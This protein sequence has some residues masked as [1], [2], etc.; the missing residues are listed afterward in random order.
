[1]IY[2][3][4]SAHDFEMEV[5]TA[6]DD[7]W[8]DHGTVAVDYD[9]QHRPD[10]EHPVRLT[11]FCQTEDGSQETEARFTREQATD[12]ADALIRD[13]GSEM[14]AKH[15]LNDYREMVEHIEAMREKGLEEGKLCFDNPEAEAYW[16]GAY[17]AVFGLLR[18]ELRPMLEAWE[19]GTP[20]FRSTEK[21]MGKES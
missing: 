2:Q 16:E 19:S 5:E 4:P 6:P 12:L 18:D 10:T 3:L 9:D 21:M 14:E 8:W 7:G 11:V 1:M 15:F 17:L 13:D 20:M